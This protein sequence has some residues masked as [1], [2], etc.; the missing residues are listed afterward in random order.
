MD[1]WPITIA[2]ADMDAF[3][4]AVEQLDNP[5]L[6]GKPLLIGPNS[7][8]GVVLT[9]SYEARPAGVGSAMPMALA[10]RRCPEAIIVAPRFDRYREV[11][12]LVMGVFA[13]FSPSVE[14]L[15]LDEAFLDMSGSSHIFGAPETFGRS[16]KAAVAD[17]TGGLT[18]SVG[19]SGTK[20][21]AKVASAY[22]KP[23]GLTIVP[24][25]RARDWLA[26]Q[27]TAVLWGAGPK[28][29]A[30]LAELG[31]Y[32]VGQ[33]TEFDP[34][35]LA[36]QLGESGRHL[37]ELAN[38]R[39]PR[40]VEGSRASRSISSEQTLERDIGAR[41]DIVPHLRQA[42]DRV[43]RRLRQQN[44]VACGVRVKLKRSDFRLLS[45]QT[46]LSEPT[47]TGDRLAEAAVALLAEFDDQ[48]PYRLI[49][50]GAFDLLP[51]NEST[52]LD[53]LAATSPRAAGLE[54]ALDSLRD[55]FGPDIVRRG[56]SLRGQGVL[57]GDTS[58]DF[59]KPSGRGPGRG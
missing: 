6:L 45:R 44:Y 34:D 28:T 3:Y 54:A 42:A 55:R 1:R 8:R 58:L 25:E 11:S 47:Q 38:G 12:K 43:A 13:D 49:G 31:L 56:A 52:Q 51:A 41:K 37:H 35:E 46:V 7:H 53:L 19:I 22:R 10:R 16:L 14:P 36:A 48:G 40:T 23:D 57:N 29:Q 15:S 59:L 24:P 20:Y 5:A 9:A 33:V 2:H 21:V 50:V 30:R 18:V 4:A 26:P 39:D 27:S 32:T 17:A